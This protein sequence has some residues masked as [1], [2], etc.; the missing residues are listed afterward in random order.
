MNTFLNIIYN[1][2]YEVSITHNHV[3]SWSDHT[4]GLDPQITTQAATT[5]ILKI[6]EPKTL[7]V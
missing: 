4:R 2:T 5:K 6:P 3:I 7:T 1:K